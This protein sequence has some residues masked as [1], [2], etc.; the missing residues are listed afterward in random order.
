MDGGH[1]PDEEIKA[2]AIAFRQRRS[3]GFATDSSDSHL[4]IGFIVKPVVE[5]VEQLT[6]NA[7]RLQAVQHRVA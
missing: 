1:D 6:V 2:N 5:V 3:N 7:H 4:T